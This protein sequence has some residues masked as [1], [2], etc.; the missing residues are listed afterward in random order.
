MQWIAVATPPFSSIEQFDQVM[1]T[2]GQ[3]PEGL[4]ARYVGSAGDGIRV[5]TLW[6]SREHADRFFAE[7]LGPV[8]AKV[9]GPDPAG[10]PEVLGLEVA[11]AYTRQPV[12]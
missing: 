3:E 12:G 4:E 1:S 10:K 5:V 9:L 7:R 6:E 8:L 11:R 2:L